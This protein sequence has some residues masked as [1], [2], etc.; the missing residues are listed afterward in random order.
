MEY[1]MFCMI[2][3]SADLSC[4]ARILWLPAMLMN[5]W[6]GVLFLKTPVDLTRVSLAAEIREHGS[7]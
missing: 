1:R 7:F 5:P 4:A 2:S 6:P 3:A